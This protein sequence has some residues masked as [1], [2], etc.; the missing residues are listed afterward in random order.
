MVFVKYAVE[1]SNR[2]AELEVFR[3]YIAEQL[4]MRGEGKY[5][6]IAYYDL[7]HKEDEYEAD[8]II[9]SVIEKAGLEVING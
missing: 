6:P 5:I 7:L 1:C 9:D 4:R 8:Q 2:R 3:V